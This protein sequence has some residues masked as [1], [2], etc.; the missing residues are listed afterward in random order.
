MRLSEC[1]YDY[2]RYTYL[3]VVSHAPDAKFD[4]RMSDTG[5]TWTPGG[6]PCNASPAVL[7]GETGG[8]LFA[9]TDASV[10]TLCNAACH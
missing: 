3:P 1:I 6:G 5:F 10:S 2:L 4:F 9:G 8:E 7:T